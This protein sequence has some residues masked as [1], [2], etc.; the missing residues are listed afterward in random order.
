MKKW[1]YRRK[2]DLLDKLEL[3]LTVLCQL[4]ASLLG[5][6]CGIAICYFF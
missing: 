6:A 4:V 1:T 5:A 3:P 2:R